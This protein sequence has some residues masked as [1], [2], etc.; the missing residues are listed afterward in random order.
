MAR[1][2]RRHATA[3]AITRAAKEAATRE[4]AAAEARAA[5]DKAEREADKAEREAEAAAEKAAACIMGKPGTVD[6]LAAAVQPDDDSAAADS[7]ATSGRSKKHEVE[8]P[9]FTSSTHP[10]KLAHLAGAIEA[11]VQSLPQAA[12]EEFG[13]EFEGMVRSAFA[14]ADTNHNGLLEVSVRVCRDTSYRLV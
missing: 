4:K 8:T 11:A 2:P 12:R 6:G 9:W 13:E 7:M 5:H 10:D 14:G 1:D 3:S